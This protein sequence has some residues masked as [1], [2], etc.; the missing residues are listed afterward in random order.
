Q[1]NSENLQFMA[2]QLVSRLVIL[3]QA[4]L[5]KRYAPD[6]VAQAFIQSRYHP[7]HGQVVGMLN[8][9]DIDVTRLLARSFTA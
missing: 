4:V 9:Q 1:Q 3:V 6:F 2:R 5:L 8:P 7:F